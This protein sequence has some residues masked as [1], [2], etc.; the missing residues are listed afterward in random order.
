MARFRA[1]FCQTGGKGLFAV[2]GMLDRVFG[3]GENLHA[4]AW[5]GV[6]MTDRYQEVED[7]GTMLCESA[8][9]SRMN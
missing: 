7:D 6:K 5:N 3:S 2:S 9:G 4:A 1:G 8:S